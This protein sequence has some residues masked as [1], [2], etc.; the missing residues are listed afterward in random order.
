MSMNNIT[1]L[2]TNRYFLPVLLV[3]GLVF[4]LGLVTV[5]SHD[6]YWDEV[7]LGYEAFSIA[8]TGEDT[9]GNSWFQVLFPAY[10]DYKAAGYIWLATPFVQS[11][12]LNSLTTRIPAVLFGTVF[13]AITYFLAWE[14]WKDKKISAYSAIAA[15]ILPW[16]LHFSTAAFEG[17][18]AAVLAAT[19]FLFILKSK[20]NVKY[21]YP[22]SITSS[23]SMLTY[24][25]NRFFIPFV[26][27]AG[28]A[29][30]YP[31]KDKKKVIHFIVS[32]LLL[33]LC[34]IFIQQSPY[35][36]VSSQYRLSTES[37]LNIE[38][39]VLESNQLVELSNGNLLARVIHHRRVL[40]LQDLLTN[41]SQH[42]SFDYLFISGD[43][44]LRHN[45]GH[46]GLL[47]LT[48]L[49]IFLLG[50]YK[51]GKQKKLFLLVLILLWLLAT[52]PASV[53]LETPH[54]LRSLNA[55]M[56]LPLILGAGYYVMGNQLKESTLTKVLLSLFVLIHA[57]NI[58]AYLYYQALVY[59]SVS[60]KVWNTGYAELAQ[61]LTGSHYRD[62]K[63]LVDVDENYYLYYLFF[64]K[65][66][67]TLVQEAS[68]LD[69]NN[70]N[71]DLKLDAIEHLDFGSVVNETHSHVVTIPEKVDTYPDFK[72]DTT[73]SSRFGKQD[74]VI[75]KRK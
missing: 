66:D 42:F 35:T 49:P 65:V 44:N 4:R 58:G 53:P 12:G 63:L 6:L 45:S 52:I 38:P 19:S 72:T 34:Y 70:P 20:D 24:V 17:H 61:V 57:A 60:A 41:I 55:I 43:S 10:G 40:Q 30:L 2:L 33:T 36:E 54:A 37:I 9:H 21:F 14:I 28:L 31:I 46:S 5:Y 71:I 27:M 8:E 3:L 47:N 75:L 25:S 16:S 74:F 18:V 59:P 48:S 39:Y 23:L 50:L 29:L 1:Y 64:T 11:F 62:Q 32:V 67:P 68:V 69:Q 13:I 7:S 73:V 56:V 26:W 22:A 51:F 15:S